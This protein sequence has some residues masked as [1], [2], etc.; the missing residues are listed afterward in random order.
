[1]VEV[2]DKFAVFRDIFM[3]AIVTPAPESPRYRWS[4]DPAGVCGLPGAGQELKVNCSE[5]GTYSVSVVVTNADGSEIGKGTG[6]VTISISQKDMDNSTKA[7]EAY[8]KLQKAKGL[9]SEGKLDEGISLA[10]EASSLDPKNTEASSLV[11]KWQNEK[12]TVMQ[13]VAKCNKLIAENKLEEAKRELDPA[14]KLHP[15]YKPVVDAGDLLKKKMDEAQKKNKDAEAKLHEAEQLAKQGKIDEAIKKAEEALTIYPEYEAAK[16]F[17]RNMKEDKKKIDEAKKL[18]QEGQ[19]LEQQG[20]L[21]EALEKYQA[22]QKIHTDNDVAARIKNLETRRDSGNKFKDEAEALEKQKK[23]KEAIDKYKESI[24][25][26]P[27]KA[28]EEKIK[29]L[30]DELKKGADVQDKINKA[31]TLKNQGKLDEAI[32]VAEDAAK[33]NR[34]AADSI[35][36]ELSQESKNQGWRAVNDRDFKTAVKRLEDAVRLNP[37]DK[38]A[39]ERLEKAKKFSSTWDGIVNKE[40]PEFDRMVNEKKPFSAHKQVL[41]IQE[42]QHDMPGGGSSEILIGM[43]ER[44]NKAFEEYNAFSQEASRKHTEYF[45]SEDWDAMLMN[46]QEMTKRELSPADEKEAQSRIQ[47]AQ[48]RLG[49]R[50]QAWNYYLSA[51]AVF[52]KGDLRQASEMLRDLKN[53]PIYFFG[54]RVRRE[55]PR[56]FLTKAS[57]VK[58]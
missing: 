24:K 18:A 11:N 8:D 58:Q 28:I 41:R 39:K 27:D 17:I 54:D 40:I 21:A 22:A 55:V 51:K 14:S 15:K 20:K 3:S 7:K 34:T 42:L 9:V 56:L 29:K 5:A 6:S 10:G 19:A 32:A 26:W 12:Q 1:M 53:K 25:Q 48:Q 49:E 57:I 43:N 44:F 30:E 37:D 50:T 33:E 13:H 35:L 45:K 31:K 23:L 47:F 46:A 52:D 2:K 36:K 16:D 38:D 4:V